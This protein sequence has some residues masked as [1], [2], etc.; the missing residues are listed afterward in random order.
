MGKKIYRDELGEVENLSVFEKYPQFAKRLAIAAITLVGGIGA[1]LWLLHQEK[2]VDCGNEPAQLFSENCQG[3]LYCVREFRGEKCLEIWVEKT[4][5]LPLTISLWADKKKL[6]GLDGPKSIPLEDNQAKRVYSFAW[7][8]DQ[9]APQ[10]LLRHSVIVG[11]T[12]AD[13]RPQAP[14]E[15]PLPNNKG[16]QTLTPNT[17]FSRE[18]LLGFD[19]AVTFAVTSGT[20]VYAIREGVVVGVRDD[21]GS[22]GQRTDVIGKENYILIQHF[23]G[24]IASYKHLGKNS[25]TVQVGDTV[26]PSQRI[27]NSGSSGFTDQPI[28]TVSVTAP[29]PPH[30]IQSFPIEFATNNGP[31]IAGKFDILVAPKDR[32]RPSS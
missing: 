13:H 14:Y 15:I 28:L 3:D 32:N 2:T 11:T 8:P 23:D 29:A 4:G 26:T 24:T 16:Y 9:K 22:G 19:H 17:P 27:A 20:P 1:G 10:Y 30:G 6:R 12:P 5:K 31:K 25:A 21:Q 7:K 18:S